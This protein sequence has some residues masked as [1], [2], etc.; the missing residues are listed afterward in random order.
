[1]HATAS[2]PTPTTPRL[3]SPSAVRSSADRLTLPR[4]PLP[5]ALRLRR[6]PELT[7]RRLMSPPAASVSVAGGPL[8]ELTTAAD[9]AAIASPGSR[10]SVVGFGSLL[11]G[12]ESAAAVSDARLL[13]P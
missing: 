9:F 10:I 7:R 8:P 3:G 6:P 2:A 4:S 1:M 5:A 13:E 11:S 12:E